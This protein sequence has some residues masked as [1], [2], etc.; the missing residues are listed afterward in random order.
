MENKLV[1]L[2]ESLLP[3]RCS[4]DTGETVGPADLVDPNTAVV[5]V[6]SSSKPSRPEQV[7]GHQHCHV[8]RHAFCVTPDG[9]T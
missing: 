7:P 2:V 5:V 1:G 4:V 3:V 9:Y 8:E 6:T